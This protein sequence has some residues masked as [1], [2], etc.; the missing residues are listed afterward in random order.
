MGAAAR[1]GHSDMGGIALEG[2]GNCS[3]LEDMLALKRRHALRREGEANGKGDVRVQDGGATVAGRAQVVNFRR[4][5]SRETDLD[6]YT[7]PRGGAGF[8]A[9]FY[10]G[11]A[12]MRH[13]AECFQLLLDFVDGLLGGYPV[14]R[15]V[16]VLGFVGGRLAVASSGAENIGEMG[17]VF[18]H[19]ENLDE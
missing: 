7:W 14:A 3:P 5:D 10:D 17:V 18:E 12:G 9:G 4:L 13:A 15:I 11:L 1:L 19:F 16:Q 8:G 6:D 2:D